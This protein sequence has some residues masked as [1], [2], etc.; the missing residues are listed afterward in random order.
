VDTS[1]FTDY[2]QRSMTDHRRWSVD[3]LR[4]SDEVVWPRDLASLLA[5][6]LTDGLPGAVIEID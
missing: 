3:E 6:L 5:T 1:G 4:H 2:E